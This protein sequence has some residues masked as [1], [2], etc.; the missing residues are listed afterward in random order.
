MISITYI[1]ITQFQGSSWCPRNELCVSQVKWMH[2]N[3]IRRNRSENRSSYI[4]AGSYLKVTQS[5]DI[6]SDLQGEYSFLFC[7]GCE[8]AVNILLNHGCKVLT[9]IVCF[10][11][12]QIQYDFML[13]AAAQPQMRKRKLHYKTKLAELRNMTFVQSI[14][15]AQH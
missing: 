10:H 1:W 7:D 13:L 6:T 4:A 2:L 9:G 15:E 11:S 8:M 3:P 5:I 12:P 14:K